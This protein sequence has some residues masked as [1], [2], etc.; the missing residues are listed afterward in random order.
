MVVTLL[1]I[2][3]FSKEEQPENANF[4]ISFTLCGMTILTKEVQPS[5]NPSNRNF[6]SLNV[7][8]ILVTL[9]G[10][11]ILFNEVQP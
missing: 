8:P 3:M 7:V 10:M 9:S 11:A 6:S 2:S 5:K 4:S 1:G